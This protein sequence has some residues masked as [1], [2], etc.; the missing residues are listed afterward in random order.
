MKISIN[1]KGAKLSNGYQKVIYAVSNGS[2]RRYQIITDI[3]VNKKFW[4][5]KKK[6]VTDR[7]PNDVDTNIALRKMEENADKVMGLYGLG[8]INEW[9]AIETLK[10]KKQAGSLEEYVEGWI[11]SEKSNATYVNY[12]QKLEAFKSFMNIKGDIRFSDVDNALFARFKRLAD[13]SIRKG[14]RRPRTYSEYA[15]NIVYICN[16]AFENNV[17]PEPI[18]IRKKHYK[19]GGTYSENLANTKEDIYQA[20]GNIKTLAEWQAVAMWLL[21]FCFR[22]LYPA[23]ISRL[24]DRL[25]KDK[26]LRSLENKRFKEG[27]IDYGRSKTNEP[28]FIRLHKKEAEVLSR[29]KTTLVYTHIDR[30]INKKKILKGVEDRINLLDYDHRE[31]YLE[32]KAMWRLWSKKFN[33]LS[34]N[35]ITFKK[36]R[37]SFLQTAE[38]L[39]G[40]ENAKKLVGHKLDRVASDFYSNYR[41]PD[42]IDKIDEMHIG[43]LKKFGIPILLASLQAKFFFIQDIKNLPDWILLNGVGSTGTMVQISEDLKPIKLKYVGCD[44]PAKYLKYFMEEKELTE[45]LPYKDEKKKLWGTDIIQNEIKRSEEKKAKIEAE[46]E[47]LRLREDKEL[48]A[49]EKS[50]KQAKNSLKKDKKVL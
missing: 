47:R 27:W 4:N 24:S 46:I 7:H 38:V 32:A 9:S 19:F 23:D 6:R 49:Y 50:L 42:M 22:G 35:S 8:K 2:G 41:T 44:T 1:L 45:A 25:L 34:D 12:K 29:L 5:A 11:K 17:I 28:M 18:T 14:E 26:R 16:Q 33:N 30:R 15:K 39:Y 13:E 36:A 31:N 20:I 21:M 43:T 40:R 48:V 10:G 3:Q 37:K